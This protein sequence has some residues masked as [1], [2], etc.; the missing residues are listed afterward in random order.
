MTP[1]DLKA[2]QARLGLSE[3]AFA[4]YL[5]VPVGTLRKWL[6]GTRAPDSAP[7]RLFDLLHMIEADAPA[8]HGRLID[9]ARNPAPVGQDGPVG[10]PMRG[11]NGEGAPAA[12]DAPEGLPAWM[13]RWE[14][15]L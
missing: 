9:A 4:A 3:T 15:P 11:G 12:A 7:H 8:L 14:A 10:A 2:W 13:A 1:S 6:N 5:G